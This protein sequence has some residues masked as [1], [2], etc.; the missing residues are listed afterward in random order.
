MQV[1]SRHV[2]AQMY[3]WMPLRLLT[4]YRYCHGLYN[5][6]YFPPCVIAACSGSCDTSRSGMHVH[7]LELLRCLC[8]TSLGIEYRI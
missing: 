8:S 3:R 5:Q 6:R 7:T 2:G 1:G 4:R